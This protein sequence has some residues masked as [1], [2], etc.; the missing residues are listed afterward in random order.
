MTVLVL[1]RDIEPQVD[2]VVEELTGRGVPVFRTD[3]AAFPRSLVL[4]ARLDPDGWDGEIA[5]EHRSVRLRDITSIW[6]RHPSHFVFPDE[7]S[8]TERRHRGALRLVRRPRLAAGAVGELP[9]PRVRRGQAA[10]T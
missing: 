6:Y 10:P 8:G 2:R 7:M 1:A 3:L 4:D 5:N 9:V